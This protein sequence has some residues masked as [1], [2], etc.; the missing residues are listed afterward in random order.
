M[1]FFRGGRSTG[2]EWVRDIVPAGRQNL[3]EARQYRKKTR[4]NATESGSR[5]ALAFR[6]NNMSS[7]AQMACGSGMW[8]ETMREGYEGQMAWLGYVGRD[9]AGGIQG[10]DDVGF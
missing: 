6:A 5:R 3:K 9:D 4:A 8:E 7:G 1:V 10:A 2:G